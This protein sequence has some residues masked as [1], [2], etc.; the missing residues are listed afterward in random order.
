MWPVYVINLADNTGR[1]ERSAAQLDAQGIAFHRIDGVNGW[2]MSD[3]EIARVYDPALNRRKARHP[4]VRPEIGCYL[5]H[6]AAWQAIAEG[7]AEGGFILEDDFRAEE[8]LA[9]AL[10][11]LSA[12]SGWDMVKLY[13]LDPD[14][15]L[16]GE[17][18]LGEGFTIGIPYRVPTCLIGYG[19]T[20]DA[21]RRLVARALPVVRPVDEEM[22][23]FWETGLR[24]AL[25]RPQPIAVGD[26]ETA[27]GTIGQ[28]RRRDVP[29]AGARGKFSQALHGLRYQLGYRLRLHYH[30]MKEGNR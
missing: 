8:T 16:I 27:T 10:R 17:R 1:M 6:V 3:D 25:V 11:L 30:R 5:S 18:L 14:T 29:V 9:G 2:A 21:A 19:V 12:D 28:S 4:L 20:R 13:S 15:K 22:K 7:E 23:F 26:Q 24:V